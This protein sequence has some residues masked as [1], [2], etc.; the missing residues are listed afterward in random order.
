MFDFSVAG[1][2]RGGIPN[3]NHKGLVSYD[4]KIKKDAFY[5]Y[6]ANWSKDLVL[7]IAERRNI[8]RTSEEIKVKVYTNTPKVTLF[9]NDKKVAMQKNTSDIKVVVFDNVTLQKG[10]NTIR[11]VSEKLSDEIVW[12]LKY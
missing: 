11:V 1:W 3:L 5:F 8:D 9:V 4:R 10:D 7:Y 2:N 12:N 6:K